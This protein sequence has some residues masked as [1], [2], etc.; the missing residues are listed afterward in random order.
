MS[1]VFAGPGASRVFSNILKKKSNEVGNVA[2][3][4]AKKADWFNS[5]RNEY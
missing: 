5:M 4:E 2:K 1:P 3:T